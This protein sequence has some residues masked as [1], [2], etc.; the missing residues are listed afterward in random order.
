M[1]TQTPSSPSYSEQSEQAKMYLTRADI[2]RLRTQ[3]APVR[4]SPPAAAVEQSQD[5][6]LAMVPPKPVQAPVVPRRSGP[7]RTWS[8][9]A[10]PDLP[11]TS[12]AEI[13]EGED[14]PRWLFWL[15][16][17]GAIV[18]GIGGSVLATFVA[19]VW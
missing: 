15:L 3:P 4:P 11:W 8:M 7:P 10:E 6:R 9:P 13:D 1:T 2:E 12:R 17:A 19:F 18:L 16:L 14:G 5:S